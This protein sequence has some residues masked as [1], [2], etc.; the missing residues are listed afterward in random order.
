MG[1]RGLSN[2]AR[3]EKFF[4][5]LAGVL[6]PFSFHAVVA[7]NRVPGAD[8]YFA[9]DPCYKE[10]KR[11]LNWWKKLGKRYRFYASLEASIF[12]NS[13]PETLVLTEREIE[14]F[15][16]YYGTS[17]KLF[18]LLPPGVKRNTQSTSDTIENRLNLRKEIG[19][20]NSTIVALFVGSGFRVKGLDRALKAIHSVKQLKSDIEFWVVGNGKASEY[21]SLVEHTGIKVH[22][23][24]GRKDVSRFY[25]AADFLLHPAYSESA[26]KVLLEALTHGLPIITTETCGYAP[27]I[28]KAKAGAVIKSPFSQQTLNQ[29][30]RT[31][32]HDREKR[33]LMSQNGLAYAANEDL[34][35]CHQTAAEII[36]RIITKND[37][38][39]V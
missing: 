23:M 4:K 11:G 34:Y 35:S 5:D 13:P 18:H 3:N 7:F 2:T 10:Q 9:A 32:I 6:T 20:A 37:C 33:Q 8:I 31:F 17:K 36:E 12:S 16:K 14:A 27:H 22:F 25:D 30:V 29:V 26:G 38:C 19:T 21:Q 39:C 28:L 15:H 24:G 1:K